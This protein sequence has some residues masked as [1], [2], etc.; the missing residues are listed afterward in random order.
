LLQ[1]SALVALPTGCWVEGAPLVGLEI[2]VPFKHNADRRHHSDVPT[3][4]AFFRDHLDSGALLNEAA[5][6]GVAYS[7]RPA[8][9]CRP[10]PISLQ[11]GTLGVFIDELGLAD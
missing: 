5:I 7:L 8:P 10:L 9:D 2:S 3:A 1:R 4:E 6:L 11:S